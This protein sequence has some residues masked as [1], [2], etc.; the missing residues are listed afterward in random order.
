VCSRSRVGLVTVHDL[1]G[2][3]GVIAEH[4]KR[5]RL[6]VRPNDRLYVVLQEMT[7][8]GQRMVPVVEERKVVGVVTVH[9]VLKAILGRSEK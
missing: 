1:E 5:P 2:A 6:V 7:L 9:G 3:R 4:V 8:L